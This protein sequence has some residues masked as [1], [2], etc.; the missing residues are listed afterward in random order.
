ME[1]STVLET[2]E[3][4]TE[5]LEA[6]ETGE[7]VE[8]EEPGGQEAESEYEDAEETEEVEEEEEEAEL[9]EFDFAGNKLTVPKG[10]L[11]EELAVKVQ[12]FGKS[13]EA[14]HTKR[15]QAVAEQSKALEARGQA[16]EKLQG[17]HG[18]TLDTYSKGL[19][20]RQELEQLNQVDINQLWQS[21]P[22]QA[23]QV[24]DTIS[25]KQAEFNSIVQQVSQ[26]EQEITQAQTQETQR[27]YVEG[28]ATVNKMIPDFEEKHAND[29]VA[30]AMSKG[31]PKE[32]AETW[33]LNPF[34]AETAFKAMMFDRMQTKA[35]KQL[36]TKPVIAKAVKPM[37]KGKGAS[38]GTKNPAR[39]T[40]D[41]YEVYYLKKHKQ[42]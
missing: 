14:A 6:E 37:P 27:R 18:E 8:D 19:A 29:V 5:A 3:V 13:M 7:V 24:S 17:L 25:A 22:D 40:P 32:H 15:S 23:R 4:E 41:E 33:P 31:V 34:A 9:L 35:T 10:S 28:K 30:Y 20:I 42:H 26:K 1:D 38:S 16:I 39:M 2:E 21:N 11:P 12:E 36:K